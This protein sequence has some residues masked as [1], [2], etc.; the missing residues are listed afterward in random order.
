MSHVIDILI[1]KYLLEVVREEYVILIALV[2]KEH[3]EIIVLFRLIIT[4]GVRVFV[5]DIWI[6][7]TNIIII[8]LS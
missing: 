4:R 8:S 3:H 1:T 2:H 6:N 7:E 5:Y